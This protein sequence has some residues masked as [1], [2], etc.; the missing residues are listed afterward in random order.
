MLDQFSWLCGPPGGEVIA[1]ERAPDLEIH[2]LKDAGGRGAHTESKCAGSTRALN[3]P[4]VCRVVGAAHVLQE[5]T[6][7][8]VG[9]VGVLLRQVN[10]GGARRAGSC[11]KVRAG[12][13][14][15]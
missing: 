10:V 13:V 4:A 2:V 12:V 5:Q 9:V 6:A 11:A 3:V 15:E 1:A 7:L 14:D 8:S